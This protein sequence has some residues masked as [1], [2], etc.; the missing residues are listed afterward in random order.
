MNKHTNMTL[1][2]GSGLALSLALVIWFPIQTRSAE[3]E[4]VKSATEATMMERCQQMMKQ[5][6]K[7]MADMQAEDT[8]LTSQLAKMNRRRRT[9]RSI[10]WQTSS[11]NW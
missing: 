8:E 11:L 7:M 2:I 6:Q 3:A 4:K 1:L 10:C 9:R 5:K